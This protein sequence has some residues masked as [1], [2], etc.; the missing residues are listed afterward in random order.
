MDERLTAAL[1]FSK[2]MITLNNRKRVLKEQ[3]QDN[4]IYYFNGGQFTVTT[5]LVSF[6][7][8]LLSLEQESTVLVDDNDIPV[9]IEDLSKFSRDIVN[10]YVTATNKYMTEYNKLKQSRTVEGIVDL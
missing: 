4:K 10:V 9:E 7:Q 6:C 2:Y 8:S 3:Y 1:E 5:Q